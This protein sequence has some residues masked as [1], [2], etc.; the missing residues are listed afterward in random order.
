MHKIIICIL[1][2][3]FSEN[4]FAKGLCNFKTANF[5]DE[6]SDP[7]SIQNI[8][9]TIP[10]SKKWVKNGLSIL[11]DINKNILEKYKKNF[12]G[13][14]KIIY[15]F[16]TCDFKADFRQVGD[17]KDH[18]KFTNGG[19]LISSLNVK[20]HEGNIL[21]STSFKLFIPET[22]NNLNEILG[23]IILRELDFLVP[24]TFMTEVEINGMKSQFL[25]QENIQKE[26]IERYGRREGPIFEGEEKYL[27]SYKN[28]DLFELENISLSRVKNSNWSIRG[29]SS[30]DITLRSFIKLQK[31]YLSYL[32]QNIKDNSLNIN[33]NSNKDPLFASYAVSLLALGGTHAL[34]PHNRNYY[35]NTL[36]DIFEPIYYDGNFDFKKI[37]ISKMNESKIN[38]LY[39]SLP[40]LKKEFIN[41]FNEILNNKDKINDIQTKFENRIYKKSIFKY[42]F[43]KNITLIKNNLILLSKLDDIESY[44]PN[45]SD[46]YENL[47]DNYFQNLKSNNL[48]LLVIDEIEKKDS[49][50]I[51]R[52]KKNGDYKYVNIDINND[53]KKI[54]SKNKFNGQDSAFIP[55]SYSEKIYTKLK[56]V[57]FLNGTIVMSDD[58]NLDI[59]YSNK[60]I[61]ISQ[62][63]HDDWLIFKNLNLENWEIYFNGASSHK[64]TVK[65]RFNEFGITGCL[66][67]Y[68]VKFN[69]SSLNYKNGYCEDSINI[70]SS[71]GT[72]KKII[73]ENSISDGLDIDFSELLLNYVKINNS[74][75]DCADFSFGDYFINDI[76]VL[77][78]GDKGISIGEK[79]KI[80]IL[81]SFVSDSYIGI[82]VKDFSQL[83]LELLNSVNTDICLEAK[84]KKQEFGGA[85]ISFSKN[86]C[87]SN[88]SLDF[89]SIIKKI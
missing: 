72:I 58:I 33:P 50:F 6:L 68:K 79:S 31:A 38:L 82:S 64:K 87:E 81:K 74:L 26:M 77:N 42:N 83:N 40:L 4:I 63:N 70:I 73:I 46:K 59:N 24:E 53:L 35:F 47:Y 29:D 32:N 52:Y 18:I 23:T 75:N 69:D 13:K 16:G 1:F 44:E 61:F 57:S 71:N 76:S 8:I 22:R 56:E 34:R 85:L 67:F 78:C 60:K 84:Q 9:I 36:E 41:D 5:I 3:F 43:I 11:T 86:N 28:Y 7:S 37:N 45:I 14:L 30:V 48:E 17:W 2:I 21:N 15:E 88:N 12:S 80:E 62:Q 65:Q 49:N 55:K 27:W 89:N 20:L 10:Q 19:N 66:N 39:Q 51:V 54:I 25:F